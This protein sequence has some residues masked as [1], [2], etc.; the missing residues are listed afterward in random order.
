MFVFNW[1]YA[2]HHAHK[3]K[4]RKTYWLRLKRLRH[5]NSKPLYQLSQQNLV[6]DLLVLHESND[7]CGA[8]QLEKIQKL[9]FPKEKGW[10]AN[11]KLELVHTDVCGP[12]SLA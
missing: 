4:A 2:Y 3:V 12:I 7:V 5:S 10:R 11:N 1:S 9:L 8:S 6:R